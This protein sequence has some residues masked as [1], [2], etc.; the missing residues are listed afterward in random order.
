[1]LAALNRPAH[2]IATCWELIQ[3]YGRFQHCMSLYLFAVVMLQVCTRVSHL[4]R[5]KTN[6][7][8]SYLVALVMLQAMLPRA[9]A[10]Q[11]VSSGRSALA[12]GGGCLWGRGRL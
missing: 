8:S 1:M 6:I 11:A 7:L 10:P 12:W 4:A 9:C 2:E 3:L 5:I